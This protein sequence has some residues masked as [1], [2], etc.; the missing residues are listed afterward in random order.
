MDFELDDFEGNQINDETQAPT[1]EQVEHERTASRQRLKAT[2][3]NIIEKYGR[4]WGSETDGMA[5][6]NLVIDLETD[7]I[8]LDNGA[9]ER[10]PVKPFGESVNIGL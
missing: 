5:S 1:L 8:I 4:D 3:E 7:K 10:T 6:Y 9:L 2:W